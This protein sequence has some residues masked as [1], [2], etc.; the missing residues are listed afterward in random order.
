MQEAQQ[1]RRDPPGVLF[2]SSL[3][4]GIDQVLALAMLFH[5]Q[6]TRSVR[7]ASISTGDFNLKNAAFLDAV[8]RFYSG[9]QLPYSPGR[10]LLPIGMATSGTQIDTASPMVS[11]VLDKSGPDG[12]AAYPHTVTGLTDTADAAA[13]TRNGMMAHEDQN[14]VVVL[15]GS[16]TN[17]IS[18]LDLPDGAEWAARKVR[19]LSIAGGRFDEGAA[20]PIVQAD[21]AGFRRLLA[22]WPTP[23][24]M[25]GTELNALTFPG[26][27]LDEVSGGVPD[28]PV[29]EA[30]RAAGSTTYD[31]PT[32][33]LAA[34]LQA[35]R[36]DEGYF[37]LSEPGTITLLDDGTTR[38]T[39]SPQGHH[40]YLSISPDEA[41]RVSEAYA[42]VLSAPPEDEPFRR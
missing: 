26:R 38:F 14:V 22:E 36:P 20:D 25:A 13:V 7:I 19:V 27:R 18:L 29:V 10:R 28:H 12:Q 3:N 21:I 34:M 33:A 6:A 40:R 30:Y 41:E 37:E 32:R 15:G 2:D 35:V 9:G 42:T 31:A 5:L 23:I 24:V 11:A 17:L 39:P 16:P 4:G 1:E 8:A